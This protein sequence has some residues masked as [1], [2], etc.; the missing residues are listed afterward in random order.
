V[1]EKPGAYFSKQEIAM[2]MNKENF[3][4]LAESMKRQRDEL[5]LQFRLAGSEVRD[6]WTELMKEWESF[7]AR[8]KLSQKIHVTEEEA[9]A[10]IELLE[11]E[12]ESFRE[13]AHRMTTEAGKA[14]HDV[15]EALEAVGVHIRGAF[16]RILHTR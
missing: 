11:K 7:R 10:E 2:T 4:R 16:N 5:A 8:E 14:A 9:R 15:G 12:W 1:H 13:R 3:D 6:E